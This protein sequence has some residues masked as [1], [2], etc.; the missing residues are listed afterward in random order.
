MKETRELSEFTFA[1]KLK[2][3]PA[4][5]RQSVHREAVFPQAEAQAQTFDDISHF[6]G[7][8]NSKLRTS[9]TALPSGDNADARISPVPGTITFH[10]SILLPLA[11]RSR[12]RARSACLVSDNDSKLTTM[13]NSPSGTPLMKSSRP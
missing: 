1:D 4:F 11:A 3:N 6:C 10:E 2:L 12:R 13:T 8:L 5:D 9:A 7:S